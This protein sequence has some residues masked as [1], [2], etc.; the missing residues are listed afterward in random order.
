M[1]FSSGLL[2]EQLYPAQR[3]VTRARLT[4]ERFNAESRALTSTRYEAAGRPCNRSVR[5]QDLSAAARTGTGAF[6]VT[7]SGNHTVEF[8]STDW[9]GNVEPT[10]VETFR[11]GTPPSGS[12]PPSGKPPTFTL[13]KLPRMTAGA[14]ARH[15]LRVKVSCTD[16]MRGAAA[17]TVSKPTKRKLHLK[18]RTLARRAIR[19]AD[20]GAKTVT[21]KPSHKTARVLRRAHRSIKAA[22]RVSLKAVGHSTRT[23]TRSVTLRR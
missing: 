18:S 7:G 11:I 21:L 1:V 14:F 10:K 19:C 15:G 17:L 8:R 6:T 5:V 13:A 3:T 23:R 2:M 22:L 4:R 20:A 12:P 9:A 16:A